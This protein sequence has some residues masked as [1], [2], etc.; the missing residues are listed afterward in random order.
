VNVV[1]TTGMTALSI[2]KGIALNSA[3]ELEATLRQINRPSR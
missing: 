2:G 1:Q 3:A